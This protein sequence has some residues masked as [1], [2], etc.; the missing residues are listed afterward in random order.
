MCVRLW[1]VHEESL[2]DRPKEVVVVDACTKFA[3][4][5]TLHWKLTLYGAMF[6]QATPIAR[7]CPEFTVPFGV[8]E[9]PVALAGAAMI[10]ETASRPETERRL[11]EVRIKRAA[12]DMTMAPESHG[13]DLG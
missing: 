7:D 11:S 1:L 8:M 9:T 3:Q 13:W 6:P 12:M 4:P 10:A 5:V 2:T